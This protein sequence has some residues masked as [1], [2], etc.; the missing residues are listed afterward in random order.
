MKSTAADIDKRPGEK[1]DGAS[2]GNV[3]ESEVD[4]NGNKHLNPG[5]LT[6][7]EGAYFQP[8]RSLD[9]VNFC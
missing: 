9:S 4:S 6:F 8:S 1:G 5:E 7:E 2:V 3:S